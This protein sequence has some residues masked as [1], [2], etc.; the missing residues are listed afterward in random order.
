MNTVSP[1]ATLVLATQLLAAP[2]S[3][4]GADRLLLDPARMLATAER[5]DFK[6]HNTFAIEH[7]DDG[8]ALRSTP[9]VSASGL[10]QGLDVAGDALRM[11]RWRWRVDLLQ[12]H[13]DIRELATEDFGAV[14]FFI[15]GEP[16]LFNRDVPTI[17]YVWT[18]TPVADGTVL[19]SRR[20]ASLKFVQL[21]GVSD[22]GDWRAETRD[23]AADFRAIFGAEPPHLK[24]IAVFNDNDDTREPASALFGPIACGGPCR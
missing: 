15:F 22:L 6:G 5:M 17:G 4:H 2:L 24:K 12:P 10:Y 8:D 16:S 14:V 11:V 7:T 23:V 19:Q 13:A 1:L 18:A 20:F 9:N 21:R 3:A